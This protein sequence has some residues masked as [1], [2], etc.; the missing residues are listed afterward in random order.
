MRVMPRD[1]AATVRGGER[2]LYSIGP[3]RGGTFVQGFQHACVCA[4]LTASLALANGWVDA[5]CDLCNSRYASARDP[6]DGY[7]AFVISVAYGSL[8]LGC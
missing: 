1:Q 3:S 4:V 2:V 7:V 6:V 5:H 8:C